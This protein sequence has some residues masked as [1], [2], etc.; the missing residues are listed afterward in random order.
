M[1]VWPWISLERESY[2]RFSLS[3]ISSQCHNNPVFVPPCKPPDPVKGIYDGQTYD[4]KTRVD[5]W[6]R[7]DVVP[8]DDGKFSQTLNLTVWLFNLITGINLKWEYVLWCIIALLV[9]IGI[10][11]KFRVYKLP[12]DPVRW[13]CRGFGYLWRSFMLIWILGSKN[14]IK[15]SHRKKVNAPSHMKLATHLM[16]FECH[17]CGIFEGLSYHQEDEAID[18]TIFASTIGLVDTIKKLLL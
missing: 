8:V 3:A 7:M 9:C 13:S 6:M 10:W 2:W 5:I 18:P 4:L 15:L 17:P 11:T 1:S 12:P 14:Y 16:N